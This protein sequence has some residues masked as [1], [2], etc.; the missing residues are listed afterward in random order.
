MQ[1]ESPTM[2]SF[3]FSYCSF[4]KKSFEKNNLNSEISLKHVL[5]LEAMNGQS[6]V[7]LLELNTYTSSFLAEDFR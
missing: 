2:Q 7:L 3:N 6:K 4:Y 1:F 5:N